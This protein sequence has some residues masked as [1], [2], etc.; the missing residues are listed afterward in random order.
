[1]KSLP[2]IQLIAKNKTLYIP[3][4]AATAQALKDYQLKEDIIL[5]CVYPSGD[6]DTIKWPK[7]KEANLV[8]ALYAARETGLLPDI[9]SVLL[10]DGR[11][12]WF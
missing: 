7:M 4:H 9:H 8:T 3:L 2:T 11:E 1:M 10:P 5:L 12:L 6:C